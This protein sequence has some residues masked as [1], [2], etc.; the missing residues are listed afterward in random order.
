[1]AAEL[2]IGSR[3][4]DY[5]CDRVKGHSRAKTAVLAFVVRSF[6]LAAVVGHVTRCAAITHGA[7]IRHFIIG[8]HHRSFSRNHEIG[9]DHIGRRIACR[10][11]K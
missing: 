5:G 2:V 10:A 6:V 7:I 3:A 1:M 9:G 4:I 8:L 11:K